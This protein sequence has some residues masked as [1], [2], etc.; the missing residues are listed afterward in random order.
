MSKNRAFL[1]LGAIGALAA[2]SELAKRRRMGSQALSLEQ[3][4]AAAEEAK[5]A[6]PRPQAQRPLDQSDTTIVEELGWLISENLYFD[7]IF[8]LHAAKLYRELEEQWAGVGRTYE[9][10]VEL[11]EELVRNQGAY[12]A[13]VQNGYIPEWMQAEIQRRYGLKP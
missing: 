9:F 12:K 10:C 8:K 5:R 11:A 4:L 7:D 2:A 6:A 1:A 13:A 3:I